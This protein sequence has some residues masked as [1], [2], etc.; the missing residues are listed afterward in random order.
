MTVKNSLFYW[1]MFNRLHR[2]IFRPSQK[3][4]D[5]FVTLLTFIIL[6][7]YGPFFSLSK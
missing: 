5:H 7:L 1:V 3:K 2:P 4:D 6:L